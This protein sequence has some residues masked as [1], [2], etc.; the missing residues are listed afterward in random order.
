MKSLWKEEHITLKNGLKATVVYLKGTHSY[1]CYVGA[2]VGSLATTYKINGLN[3][4]S[5]IAHFL[6]HRLFDTPLGDAFEL[7]TSIGCDSNAYT[8]YQYTTYYFE[9]ASSLIE[10]IKILLS[11]TTKLTFD[12][13]SVEKEKPI[14]IE[15]LHMGLDRPNT[16]LRNGLY[17]NLFKEYPLKDEIVGS[18]ESINLTTLEDL[19]R[20]FNAYYSKEKLHL[21]LIGDVNEDLLNQIGNIEI[22]DSSSPFEIEHFEEKD[23]S[24]VQKESITYMDVPLPLIT[25]GAKKLDIQKRLELD[26]ETY[27]ALRE[28]VSALLFSD[29]EKLVRDMYKEGL[30]SS[31]IYGN[32]LHVENVSIIQLNTSSLKV[33]EI[34]N[35][36]VHFFNHIED[37]VSEKSVER[38]M[39]YVKGSNLYLLDDISNFAYLIVS[40]AMRGINYHKEIEALDKINY[41]LIIRYVKEWAN[42]EVSTHIIKKESK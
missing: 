12:E 39:N 42:A 36:F 38:I 21:F 26:N 40:N 22:D 11:M 18:E 9:T 32:I 4:P 28:V 3:T 1:A 7:F 25:V 30:I 33:K 14:I 37:Y 6:E 19:K 5:G 10:G 41:D 31:P 20:V 27:E 17:K 2:P 23:E 13:K 8:T 16:R 29:S 24:I 35:K 34:Q 15:E